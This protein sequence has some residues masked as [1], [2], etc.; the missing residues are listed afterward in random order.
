[1]MHPQQGVMIETLEA[2]ESLQKALAE[3]H[4]G[5]WPLKR[6]ANMTLLEFLCIAGPNRIRFTYEGPIDG[7]FHGP[8]SGDSAGEAI[9]CGSRQDADVSIGKS[10]ATLDA[11][12]VPSSLPIR[13]TVVPIR[14]LPPPYL[15]PTYPDLGGDPEGFGG[16][17]F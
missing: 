7:E 14:P 16:S 1:M 13:P 9:H 11:S 12:A 5:P 10:L 6:L 3:A 15:G 4:T 8:A 2:H 17:D